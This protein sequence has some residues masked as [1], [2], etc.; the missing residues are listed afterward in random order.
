MALNMS[1]ACDSPGLMP[2]EDAKQRIWQSVELAVRTEVCGLDNAIG[3]ILSANIVSPINVP[4]YNNSAMDGYAFCLADTE[5]FSTL[6]QIG[7]SFA[8]APFTGQLQAGECVR[9]MTGAA[10]PQGADTVVMQENVTADGDQ[11]CIMRLPKIGDAIRLA[12]EDIASGSVVL[13]AGKCLTPVDIGLLASLGIH[14][15]NLYKKLKVAV[16]S[17]GTELLSVTDTNQQDRIYDSNRPM[18]IAMLERLQM[19]VIDLGI[20]ADDKRLIKAAFEQANQ[21][22]DCVI[23]SGG[24]SVGEADFTREVLE[25]IGQIDFWK[26]AIKPGKPLAFGRL[27]DSIFFGL[28]GNPVSAAV[29]FDQ[30]AAPTLRWMAGE[31]PSSQLRIKARAMNSLRKRPGRTDYQRGYCWTNEE[32]ECCVEVS[33]SQG[34]GILSGF[35]NSNCYVVLESERGGVECG[36]TVE[37]Q[38]FTSPMVC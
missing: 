38:L 21:L 31:S 34:S 22:A 8:G 14:Q 25:E 35:V 20:V 7:K 18:L 24:V 30:I 28:P 23:T 2:I 27:P 4:G 29:T 3:R 33:R 15:L 10:I 32:G 9:I 37:V 19:Q 5:T 13:E 1:C 12:G 16:F 11:I 17:T 26:L 6:T 36:D